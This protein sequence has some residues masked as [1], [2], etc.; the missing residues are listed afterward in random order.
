[1]LANTLRLRDMQHS[2]SGGLSSKINSKESK[3]AHAM[4]GEKMTDMK[5]A[6]LSKKKKEFE[7]AKDKIMAH[8]NLTKPL[9]KHNKGKLLQNLEQCRLA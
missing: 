6:R 3:L 5:G 8:L 1:M 7:I 4:M 9:E 2:N